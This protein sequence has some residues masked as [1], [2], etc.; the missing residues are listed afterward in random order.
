MIGN[1]I[2]S[3]IKNVERFSWY[4]KLRIT[5]PK[6]VNEQYMGFHI[7]IM[8]S[9]EYVNLAKIC[10]AS[11]LHFNPNSVITIHCDEVTE[12]EIN[13]RI[14]YFVRRRKVKVIKDCSSDIP[15]QAEKLRIISS[16]NGTRDFFVDADLRWNG[17]LLETKVVTFFVNEFKLKD[18]SPF[19][20][21]IKLKNFSVF[22][23]ASMKNT[24]FFTFNGLEVSSEKLYSL[25]QTYE[26]I[27]SELRLGTVARL[28]LPVISRISEQLAFSMVVEQWNVPIVYLKQTDGHLDGSFLESSYYGATGVSF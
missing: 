7:L 27:L 8:A 16:L 6:F 20:E 12:S 5:K 14:G 19:R 15:W 1:S 18:R 4:F 23:D 9:L 22:S 24:S 10:I 25:Q 2:V 26:R 17:P 13:E 11:L 21:F 28:D 3:T